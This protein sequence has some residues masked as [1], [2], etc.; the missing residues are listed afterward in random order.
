MNKA[1]LIEEPGAVISRLAELGI[2]NAELLREAI[3]EGEVSKAA[4]HKNV[5]AMAIGCAGWGVT[6]GA[7]RNRLAPHGWIASSEGRLE[8]TFNPLTMVAIAVTT[9]DEATGQTGQTPRTKHQKGIATE[10][11]IDKNN[12][13]LSL[14]SRLD[15]NHPDFVQAGKPDIGRADDTDV[16]DAVVEVAENVMLWELLKFRDKNEIRCELSLPSGYGVDGVVHSWAER[17]I[18]KPIDLDGARKAVKPA[19][20]TPAIDLQVKRRNRAG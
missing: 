13:Q 11:A 19:E 6:V 5:P 2:P 7:T 15:P 9:G 18:L 10:R 12:K 3:A 8:T 14:L 16:D 17:I 1:N 20:P 4:F